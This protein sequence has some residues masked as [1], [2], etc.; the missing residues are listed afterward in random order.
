MKKTLRI[1]T[2]LSVVA[3]SILF[4]PSASAIGP[5]YSTSTGYGDVACETSGFFTIA[6]N[7]VTGNTSC[8]GT[9]TIPTGVTSIEYRAFFGENGVTSVIISNTVLTIGD[10]AFFGATSLS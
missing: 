10:Y 6:S 2:V 8:A 4:V 5:L 7:V 9:V 1:L 3:S